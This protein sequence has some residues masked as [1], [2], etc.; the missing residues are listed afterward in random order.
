MFGEDWTFNN[1]NMNSK[2]EKRNE[3]LNNEIIINRDSESNGIVPNLI[4]EIYNLY[5]KTDSN[6]III[7]CSYIQIYNEKIYDLLNEE[8]N[9]NNKAKT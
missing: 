6:N 3:L 1:I 2:K 9:K 5:N 8:K 7:K 4:L